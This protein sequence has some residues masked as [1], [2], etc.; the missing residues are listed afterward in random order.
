ML[1]QGIQKERSVLA[2]LPYELF[3]EHVLHRVV[4]HLLYTEAIPITRDVAYDLTLSLQRMPNSIADQLRN[5]EVILMNEKGEG[6]GCVV[7]LLDSGIEIMPVNL[8]TMTEIDLEC[9]LD[10]AAPHPRLDFIVFDFVECIAIS[11]KTLLRALTYWDDFLRSDVRRTWQARLLET[12]LHEIAAQY[13]FVGSVIE[14]RIVAPS[15]ESIQRYVYVLM[16]PAEP[17]QLYLLI[18]VLDH[19]IRWTLW[20]DQR[21]LWNPTTANIFVVNADHAEHVWR[22]E[23]VRDYMDLQFVRNLQGKESVPTVHGVVLT[24]NDAISL[25]QELLRQIRNT[26]Y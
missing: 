4:S 20:P 6:K 5:D 14:R 19:A 25:H 24:E 3:S 9:N 23:F 11:S 26:M 18:D 8:S 21:L 22:S 1:I 15:G 12:D 17:P 2:V 16:D 13:G 10:E 7:T